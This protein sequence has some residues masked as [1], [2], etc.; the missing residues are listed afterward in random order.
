MI[1]PLCH[2]HKLLQAEGRWYCPQCYHVYSYFPVY[3]F[4]FGCLKTPPGAMFAV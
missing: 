1:C 4:K 3:G 2:K